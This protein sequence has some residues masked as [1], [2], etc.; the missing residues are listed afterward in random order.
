MP[1]T[2]QSIALREPAQG[3]V[4]AAVLALE[5]SARGLCYVA[6]DQDHR[7]LDWGGTEA[8]IHKNAACRHA[9]RRLTLVF[10]PRHIVV[11]DG[12]AATSTRRARIR[13]LLRALAQDAGDSG[14]GVAKIPRL[15]VRQHMCRYPLPSKHE[16]AQSI[17]KLYPQLVSRLPKKR[18]IWESEHY[19]LA[20]FEAAAL[21][22]TFFDH[23]DDQK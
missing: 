18:R 16:M 7:L 19:S 6:F 12:D 10:Q 23:F 17:C 4:F 21:G 8:R 20:L 22:V 13:E 1:T 9:A 5:P 3:D 15:R 2:A 11:E 14:C